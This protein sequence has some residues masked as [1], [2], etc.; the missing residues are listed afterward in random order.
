M[1]Y[2]DDY[3]CSFDAS[4]NTTYCD[5]TSTGYVIEWEGNDYGNVYDV[6]NGDLLAT[7]GQASNGAFVIDWVDG[8]A[9]ECTVVGDVATLCVIPP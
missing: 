5:G 3:S 2:K 9:G 1:A 8:A 6:S 7:V 4:S